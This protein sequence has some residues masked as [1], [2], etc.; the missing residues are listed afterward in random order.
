ME[1]P[2]WFR[3]YMWLNNVSEK[4][5]VVPYGGGGGGGF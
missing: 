1:F 4:N 2:L 5:V 3:I